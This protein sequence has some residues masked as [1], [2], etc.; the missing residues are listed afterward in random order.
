MAAPTMTVDNARTAIMSNAIGP[1]ESA[2][3]AT[4]EIAKAQP[5]MI[6]I[7]TRRCVVECGARLRM[8]MSDGNKSRP[9]HQGVI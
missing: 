6:A 5:R 9:R 2:M 1:L 3:T 7:V 4:I 8:L